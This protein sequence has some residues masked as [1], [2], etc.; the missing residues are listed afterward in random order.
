MTNNKKSRSFR[1][2]VAALLISAAIWGLAW[3]INQPA[4]PALSA[5]VFQTTMGWGYDILINDSLF[6]HQET[7]PVIGGGQGFARK[8]WAQKAARLI[9]NKMENGR[10]PRLTSFD[11]AQICETDIP[12]Y[13]KQG[14]PE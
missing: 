2:L 5:H 11:I 8:E 13:G 7:M 1:I 12:S 9:I 6:I 10:H 14:T 3:R 4:R